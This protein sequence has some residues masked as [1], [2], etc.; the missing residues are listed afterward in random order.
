M[1]CVFFFFRTKALSAVTYN[2]LLLPPSYL[3]VFKFDSDCLYVPTGPKPKN[4]D[5]SKSEFKDGIYDLKPDKL[6]KMKSEQL[7]T[8]SLS[9]KKTA[10]TIQHSYASNNFWDAKIQEILNETEIIRYKK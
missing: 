9:V 8:T 4:Y 5:L 3:E 6:T 7:L 10:D 1:G 2:P